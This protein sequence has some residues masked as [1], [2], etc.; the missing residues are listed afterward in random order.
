MKTSYGLC[1][2]LC[3]WVLAMER[4]T[5][6]SI[7]K[8][9]QLG[10]PPSQMVPQELSLFVSPS[11]FIISIIFPTGK[12]GGPFSIYQIQSIEQSRGL[13]CIYKMFFFHLV[14]LIKPLLWD[15]KH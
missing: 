5:H 13:A 15:L 14:S 1:V 4:H 2:W 6:F 10:K 11:L 9:L 8:I 3:T 12:R 7:Q